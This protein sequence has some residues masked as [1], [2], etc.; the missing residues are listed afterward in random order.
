[1]RT[2]GSLLVALLAL[3]ALPSVAHGLTR[4]G[5]AGNCYALQAD[6][7]PV[8]GGEQ[9][10][11]QATA[12]GSYLLYRPDGTFLTA[13]GVG[14]APGPEADWAVEEAGGDRFTL[15]PKRGGPA[16][17]GVAFS[18]AE[19]CATFPEAELNAT[20]APARGATPFGR[21]GGLVEGHM[22]WMTFEYIGGNF[23]CGRPWHPYGI[24]HALPDCATIEGPQGLGAPVQ[25]T[26]NFGNPAQAHDTRGYP[27]LTEWSAGNLTYEALE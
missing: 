14:E 20:G 26:L 13:D 15:I 22:H 24:E 11:M 3:A 1:V 2:S 7:A 8:A 5:L 21:V 25:N 23:H 16:L 17:T 19:G 27:Q 4:Y 9:V 12:L 18:P 10:R 6:G